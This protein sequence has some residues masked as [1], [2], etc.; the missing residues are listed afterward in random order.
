M[1]FS[2]FLIRIFLT[3]VR[4]IDHSFKLSLNINSVNFFTRQS[5]A[6][7]IMKHKL[8]VQSTENIWNVQFVNRPS[9]NLDRI[10][11]I[12]VVLCVIFALMAAVWLVVIMTECVIR[13]STFDTQF[14]VYLGGRRQRQHCRR[15]RRHCCHCCH[16]R[17]HCCRHRRRQW[18]H[19]R[20]RRR[21]ILPPEMIASQ[22]EILFIDICIPILIW[23]LSRSNKH[24]VDCNSVSFSSFV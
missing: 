8:C 13:S 14:P 22:I 9:I 12:L 23:S 5:L 18:C 15:Y 4:Y 2:R 6:V 3:L 7:N 24:I 20:L 1:A 11:I 10:S 21:S 19:R 17:Y 16:R